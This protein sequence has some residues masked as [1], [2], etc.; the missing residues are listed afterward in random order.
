MDKIANT[1]EGVVLSPLR[2][3]PGENGDVFHALKASDSSFVAFG[4]CYFSAIH[5][6]K[7]KGW[8]K[9]TRMTLNLV[10]PIGEIEFVLFDD[11]LSSTTRGVF[12]KCTLSRKN[13]QRLTV[14]PGIW[15]AFSGRGEGESILLNIASIPHEPEEAVTL[16][17]TNDYI[18]YNWE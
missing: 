3:I 2:I 4:E 9:H 1:L 17:L 11:R 6:D 13:Y 12:F 14:P 5:K 16:M 8:K 10:V 18:K 7:R 15:M